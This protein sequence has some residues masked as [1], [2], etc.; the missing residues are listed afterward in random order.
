MAAQ[1]MAARQPI[2]L[3]AGTRAALAELVRERQR[4]E[5]QINAIVATA[6]EC[7]GA[8]G[9]TLRDVNVG[10]EPPAQGGGQEGDDGG[11]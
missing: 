11:Q 9:Y 3:P 6:Q 2:P 7:L 8:Q 10:F 5:G 1:S 4:I